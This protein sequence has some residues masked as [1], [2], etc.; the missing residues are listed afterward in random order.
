MSVILC[1][2]KT[3]SVKIYVSADVEDGKLK[4]TGQDLGIACE[5]AWGDSEYEYYYSFNK[6]NTEKLRESLQQKSDPELLDLLLANFNGADGCSK[7]R[8]YCEGNDIKY[9]FFSC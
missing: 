6:S 1:D 9:E 5:K 8:D 7:L 3:K 4:I 2:E